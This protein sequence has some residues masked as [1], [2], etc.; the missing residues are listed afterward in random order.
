MNYNHY[1]A[2]DWSQKVMAFARLTKDSDH[3]DLK[4]LPADLNEFKI[5]LR[6][7]KG[8]KILTVEESTGS[9]WLYTELL[10]E[11]DELIIC[12]PHRNHLLKER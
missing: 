3:L 2:L 8:T 4:E 6:C 5:Y 12:D 9:Q 10:D 1:I 11:V 7:L